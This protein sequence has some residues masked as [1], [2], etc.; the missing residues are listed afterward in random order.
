MKAI[1]IVEEAVHPEGTLWRMGRIFLGPLMS[2]VARHDVKG[3][4]A[5]WLQSDVNRFDYRFKPW[6]PREK[7]RQSAE[8]WRR[9]R[10]CAY[11][12]SLLRNSVSSRLLRLGC[13]DMDAVGPIIESADGEISQAPRFVV[14][15]QPG[16]QT[17]TQIMDLRVADHLNGV[18]LE[19]IRGVEIEKQRRREHVEPM[20]DVI[21][22]G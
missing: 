20:V 22:R 19:V 9:T 6:M 4:L 14:H 3:G 18:Y 1:R 15:C 8:S 2:L 11:K 16:A 5:L 7:Y 12:V 10:P 13:H 21:R 17:W